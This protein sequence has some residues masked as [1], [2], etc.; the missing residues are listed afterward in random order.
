MTDKDTNTFDDLLEQLITSGPDAMGYVFARLLESDSKLM[1]CIYFSN[2][3][4]G[5]KIYTHSHACTN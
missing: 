2:N 4:S 5:V 1:L 3:F